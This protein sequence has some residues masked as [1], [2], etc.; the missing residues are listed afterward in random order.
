MLSK[1]SSVVQVCIP[2][3]ECEVLMM[4]ATGDIPI[5]MV[6]LFLSGRFTCTGTQQ[7]NPLAKYLVD[8]PAGVKQ[9]S[10]SFHCGWNVVHNFTACKDGW[11]RNLVCGRWLSEMHNSIT[12]LWTFQTSEKWLSLILT[13]KFL[14]IFNSRLWVQ[15][16]GTWI[17]YSLVLVLYQTYPRSMPLYCIYWKLAE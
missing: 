16:T 10:H 11:L 1:T 8:H 15:K 7:D 17:F 2:K 14:R 4:F 9:S 5:V 12:L 6:W 13:I 3:L